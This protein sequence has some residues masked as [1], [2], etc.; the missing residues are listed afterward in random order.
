LTGIEDF[1]LL[2]SPAIGIMAISLFML[3]RRRDGAEGPSQRPQRQTARRRKAPTRPAGE[4]TAATWQARAS[5]VRGASHERSGAPNQDCGRAVPLDNGR[6][7]LLVVADGHGDSLHARSDRGSRFAVDAAVNVL[8][9]WIGTAAAGGAEVRNSAGQLPA[10]IVTA[11]QEMV[12]ADLARQPAADEIA[13]APQDKVDLIRRSPEILYGSTLLAVAINER[14]AAFLQIGD[15]DLL[16]VA[17]DGSVKRVVP[18]RDDLPLNQTESLCQSDARGRFRVQVD[19]FAATPRP[20]LVM[21]STDGYSNSFR[22]D[23]AFLKVA[24]DIEDYLERQGIDW[25]AQHLNGWLEETSRIGSGDDITVAVAWSGTGSGVDAEDAS[26]RAPWWRQPLIAGVA[27]L[28]C[29]SLGWAVWTWAPQGFRDRTVDF[30]HTLSG[31]AIGVW[32]EI[33]GQAPGEKPGSVGPNGDS[34]G[35][36]S[37]GG[38]P[39]ATGGAEPVPGLP[40]HYPK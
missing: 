40:L 5:S 33:V 17:A 15:G 25:I 30:W 21:A 4:V 38:K 35:K 7:V 28:L 18:V 14:L 39:S 29:L 12:A 11:W 20:V 10:K 26:R 1:L 13:A 32:H 31:K 27:V 16:T 22:D 36:P 9:E 34:G 23:D 6:G 2:T 3:R 19:S 8:S 37:G 24:R